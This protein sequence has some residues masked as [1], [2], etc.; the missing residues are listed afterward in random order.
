MRDDELSVIEELRV[1]IDDIFDIDTIDEF[2]VYCRAVILKIDNLFHDIF[3]NIVEL[4]V[5]RLTV[6]FNFLHIDK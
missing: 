2:I 3:E 1:L 4:N 6:K 5:A